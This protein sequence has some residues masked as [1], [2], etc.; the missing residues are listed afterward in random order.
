M[1][2]LIVTDMDDTLLD[3]N[4]EIPPDFPEMLEELKAKNIRLAIASGRPYYTLRSLFDPLTTGLSYICDN[5]AFVVH[6]DEIVYKN[7]LENQ[8]AKDIVQASRLNP[9]DFLILCGLDSGYIEPVAK[10]MYDFFK[11]YYSNLEIVNDLTKL[12]KEINKVT[13]YNKKDTMKN[14]EHVFKPKFADTLHVVCS[15][16]VW[17]DIM[18]EGVNKGHGLRRIMQAERLQRNEVMVFGDYYN[19]IEMLQEVDYSF[20]MENAPYDMRQYGNYIA[21]S[22]KEHGVLKAIRTYA[23]G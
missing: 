15:G 19:D 21:A 1:I 10:E 18:N 9:D 6:K 12:A 17:I 2:K 8:L 13:I 3:E 7:L 11:I 4:K 22:N 20:V 23:L 16:G 14:L 5:G